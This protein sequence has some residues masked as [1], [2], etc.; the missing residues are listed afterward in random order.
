MALR[1]ILLIFIAKYGS[2]FAQ[3]PG[4]TD[5]LANNFNPSAQVNNGS[6]TYNNANISVSNS[7]NLASVL[8]ET[9]GLCIWN[10]SIWTHNDSQDTLLYAI[11]INNFNNIGSY[12]LNSVRNT[13]WEEISQDSNYFYVGD[14]GN[15]SNGNRTD[16]KILR[17]NKTSLLNSSPIIDTI[18]FNYSTQTDFSGTGG[19][20]TNFDCEAFIVSTDSIYL[21]TKE[22]VSN[23]SSLFSLPKTPGNYSAN[24]QSNLNVQGLITAAT[25]LENKHL[26][27]L[28]GYS[29]LLQPFIYLL[30]DFN[31]DDFFGGNKRKI[32]INLAFHQIE[33]ICTED[34]L[35]YYLSN[36]KLVQSFLTVDQKIHQLDLT[37]YLGNYLNPV[38]S[39]TNLNID[40]FEYDLHNSKDQITIVLS[41]H[42]TGKNYQILNINGQLIQSGSLRENRNIISTEGLKSG[43]Y[44][45][46]LDHKGRLFT[47]L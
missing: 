40:H 43:T 21:F 27:V 30:Y 45:F 35:N 10:N 34:G 5:P 37:N 22:W 38:P 33:G 4:C 11:D 18:F 26:I 29:S 2:L 16:L 20:N 9:S 8:N 6:C 19:N 31:G 3:T 1:I 12:P 23:R 42:L 13:D 28:S 36:E 17:I 7:Q 15:N 41:E 14:F 24:Y 32:N 25:Y 39:H 44:I 47:K 46:T